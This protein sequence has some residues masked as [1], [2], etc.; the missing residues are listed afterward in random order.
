M[1]QLRQFFHEK[2]NLLKEEYKIK[3]TLKLTQYLQ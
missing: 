1:N 2:S 3:L